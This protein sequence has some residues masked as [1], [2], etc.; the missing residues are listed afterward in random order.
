M[1]AKGQGAGNVQVIHIQSR[2]ARGARRD[3]TE[4]WYGAGTNVVLPVRPSRP[5]VTNGYFRNLPGTNS[6]G[7]YQMSFAL[8]LI[9]FV[10]LIGGVAWGMVH[11]GVATT[12]VA[13]TCVI[14]LGLGILT[15]V[16]NERS[17]DRP[18]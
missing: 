18:S 17:K 12:W 9:G 6:H 1:R 10:I 4:S 3:M 14:L 8:F 15:A 7:R 13:I 16:K 11:A 2:Q 5:D